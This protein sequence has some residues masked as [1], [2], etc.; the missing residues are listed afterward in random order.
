MGTVFRLIVLALALLAASSCMESEAFRGA[1]EQVEIG[2]Q[3]M[4]DKD[5]SGAITAYRRAAALAPDFLD[6]RVALARALVVAGMYA[7]ARKELD[8]VQQRE[9]ANPDAVAIWA[10]ALALQGRFD[11]AEGAYTRAVSL[12]DEPPPEV[13]GEKAVILA[14]MRKNEEA[15]ELFEKAAALDPEAANKADIMLHWGSAL[16][17]VGRPDEAVAK[18]ERAAEIAPDQPIILNNLGFLLYRQGIDRKRGIA[19]MKKAVS[20]DPGSPLIL[21]NLGWALLDDKQFEAAHGLLRRATAATDPSE[22][23]FEIR[24]QHLQQAAAGITRADPT[25]DMPNVVLVLVDTLRADHLGAYGYDRPTSPHIDALA[26]EGVLFRQAIGQAPWTSAS[27]ASLMT[28][29]YPSVHGLDQ[30]ARWG[31]GQTSAGGKLPFRVQ[32]SLSPSQETLAEILR[33]NGYTTAGFVSNIYVNSIFGFGQGFD[34]YDDQHRGYSRDVSHVKQ[35][36]EETNRRIFRWLESRPDEPFFLFAHYND[37]HWP[38]DPPSPHGEAYI[39]GYGGDL[40]PEKTTAIVE[41]QGKPIT[42]LSKE[43]LRYIVGLYDGEIHYADDQVGR[44]ID[45]LDAMALDRDLLIVFT[46]DHG[47]EFL[48]HGSASHGYTLYDEM[49]HVPLILRWKGKLARREV[50]EQA[51]LIDVVP[52]LLDLIGVE[53]AGAGGSGLAFQ[54]ES[55]RPLLEGAREARGHIAFAEASYTGDQRAVRTPEGQKLIHDAASNET[56][57]F[58]LTTDPREQKDLWKESWQAYQPLSE[59]LA[60]WKETNTKLA[61]EHAAED[62]P[63][64]VVLDPSTSD[65]LEALGYIE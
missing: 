24:R 61:A 6:A 18:Y 38:Y 30:G 57:A 21:H 58:D 43:D 52:T 40:T 7:D 8:F 34:I 36:G 27:I 4:V 3:A 17:R 50:S 65:Q 41:Q 29:L 25:P 44:L 11:E 54:G 26:R 47:E 45:K 15:L 48:D 5:L 32:K 31:G 12:Y 33:R 49:I 14:A 42:G 59:R 16:E 23:V 13:L 64:Q 39:K 51:E 46:A 37:P 56:E 10:K 53:H 20:L 19:L 55:L 9:P 1:R 35:R 22:P 63:A 60:R 62:E 28:G 2:N